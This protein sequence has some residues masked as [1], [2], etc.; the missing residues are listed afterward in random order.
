MT[1][2]SSSRAPNETGSNPDEPVA[3]NSNDEPSTSR[4]LPELNTAAFQ[5]LIFEQLAKIQDQNDTLKQRVQQLEEGQQEFYFDICKKF[6]RG[7]RS[8]K[9]GVE[10]VSCLKEVFKDIVGIMSGERVRFLDHSDENV[11]EQEAASTGESQLLA[12]NYET[13]HR[14]QQASVRR[15]G[16]A[17]NRPNQVIKQEN[18]ESWQRLNHPDFTAPNAPTASSRSNDGNGGN[19]DNDNNDSANDDASIHDRAANY[20]L[21]RLLKTVQDLAREYFEGLHGQPSVVALERRFGP[22]WR[23]K[24]SERSF[25]AKRMQIIHRII[26]V[27]DHPEKYNLPADMSLKKAIRVIENMRLGNNMFHGVATRMTLNQLYIYLAKKM[28]RPED[29][30]LQ[31]GQ[32]ARPRRLQLFEQRQLEQPDQAPNESSASSQNAAESADTGAELSVTTS[33]A[34]NASHRE[35]A[36]SINP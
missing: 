4:L 22:S 2:D 20:R 3:S 13:L 28:D 9:Q 11:T 29:Y 24:G 16:T 25:F 14:M 17:S 12:S 7:L 36:S 30:S 31:L 1:L 19:G 34:A 6:E 15:D 26:D 10:E 18:S 32:V 8:S 23:S 5:N 27:R 35:D 33:S 21:N